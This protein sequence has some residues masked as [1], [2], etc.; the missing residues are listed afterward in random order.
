MPAY[1]KVHRLFLQSYLSERFSAEDNVLNIY[2]KACEVYGAGYNPDNL[3]AFMEELNE[4]LFTIDME[5]RKG[6]A[7]DSGVTYWAMVNLN[8]DEVAQMATECTEKEI[9]YFKHLTDLIVTADDEAFEIS[10]TV[11]L[12]ETHGFNS[13]KEAQAFLERLV[14]N[15]WLTER[16]GKLSLSLRAVLE[17]QTYLKDG[18]PDRINECTLCMEI[19]TTDVKYPEESFFVAN[20]EHAWEIESNLSCFM[21]RWSGVAWKI[22]PLDFTSIAATNTSRPGKAKACVPRGGS[23]MET[24]EGAESGA[25]EE[26]SQA[27]GPSQAAQRM[28]NR[29]RV[30]ADSDGSQEQEAPQEEDEEEQEEEEEEEELVRSTRSKGKGKALAEPPASAGK[31]RRRR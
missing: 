2:R 15:H 12:R 26:D 30:V 23:S 22:V 17:L 31:K 24:D 10:S 8:G 16:N 29:N 13:K 28:S 9:A 4:V 11:A 19:V 5:M 27:A 6:H 3:T 14:K 25:E 18:F 21:I 1:G 20:C 7:P